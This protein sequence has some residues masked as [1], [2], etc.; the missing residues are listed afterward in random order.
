MQHS[1]FKTETKE[2]AHGRPLQPGSLTFPLDEPL[3][4]LSWKQPFGTAMLHGKIE[5]RSWNTNVR[6]WV[7]ICASLK[8]YSTEKIFEI[9]GRKLY[10]DMIMAMDINTGTIDLLG[11]AIAI[12]RLT[13]CRPMTK[14]DEE[15]CFVKYREGLF[16]HIYE[17]VKQIEPLPWKGSRKWKEVPPEVKKAII[18]KQ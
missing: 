17:D 8:N 6:G 13:A 4:A 5:T 10:I 14:A 1:L 9:C 3:T 16:C 2:E 15:K 12:G 18:I 11:H 7:M